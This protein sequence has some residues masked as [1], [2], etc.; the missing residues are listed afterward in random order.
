MLTGRQIMTVAC[1]RHA[2]DMENDLSSLK[3][4]TVQRENYLCNIYPSVDTVEQFLLLIT[5]FRFV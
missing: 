4:K 2:Y 5:L 1:V 3:Q